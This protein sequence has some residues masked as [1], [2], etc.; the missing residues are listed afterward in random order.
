MKVL[1]LDTATTDLVTGIVDTDTGESI[2][3]VI[4]GTRAHNEQLIPT[5]EELLADASLTYADLSAIVVGTGPGPFT[6]LRVGMA[7]ASALGVAL[8]LPVH[9]VCTLDAIAHGRTGEWLVAIDARRKEVYWATYVD[10][11]RRSGPNVSKPETLD[12][13]AAGLA[14]PASALLVFPESIAPRLPEDIADLPSEWATPR[15]EGL[16]ACADLSAEPE[17]LVPLYL[18]RPDA[19]EPKAKPRSA[20]LVGGNEETP[21]S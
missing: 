3:R 18:R 14:S 9:G 5:I 17:P 11:E 12:L 21:A 1:A 10:G 2:D 16:V 20:A 4:S 6:G 8:P 13:S 15:A 7:T 19:V